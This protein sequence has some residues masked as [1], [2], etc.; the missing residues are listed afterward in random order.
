MLSEQEILQSLM[1]RRTR[2]GAPVGAGSDC[3]FCELNRE[4][5]LG[6]FALDG[7][8]F[9]FWSINPQVHAF[10]DLSVMETIEAQAHTI[11]TAR[12]IAGGHPL[13]ISPITLR[14]RFNPVATGLAAPTPPGEL[15]PQ[16]DSRQPTEFAAEWTRTSLHAL[17]EAGVASATYFETAG[18]RGGMQR[19]SAS[20]L[21]GKFRSQPAQ[22]FPVYRALRDFQPKAFGLLRRIAAV[23]KPSAE[24]FGRLVPTFAAECR[25]LSARIHNPKRRCVSRSASAG[26]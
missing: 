10:D 1:K 16:V 21:L 24:S 9:L 25:L 2:V 20:P 17:A 13:V 8:D 3:N 26:G 18:W 7:A 5:A 6:N 15:P 4:H 22:V 14:Q 12:V 23:Q 11:R 19:E